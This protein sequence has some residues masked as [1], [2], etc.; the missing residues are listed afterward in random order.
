MQISTIAYLTLTQFSTLIAAAP[1]LA[2][3]S[4]LSSPPTSLFP[5]APTPNNVTT[6]PTLRY[7]SQLQPHP[8]ITPS[9]NPKIS[10]QRHSARHP[11]HLVLPRQHQHH[12]QIH[13]RHLHHLPPPRTRIQSPRRRLF[14]NPIPPRT[15]R[16]RRRHTPRKTA[17]LAG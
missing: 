7:V 10:P 2:P 9:S 17:R 8:P 4:P 16:R 3:P 13:P 14:R 15:P 5:T 12:P 6:S 1:P 11:L